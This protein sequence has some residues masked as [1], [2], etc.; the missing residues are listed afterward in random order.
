MMWEE[1]SL[2]EPE[3]KEGRKK[4]R[5]RWSGVSFL[6]FREGGKDGGRE[7]VGK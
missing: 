4:K 6:L 3:T 1:E 7:P 5:V 2:F